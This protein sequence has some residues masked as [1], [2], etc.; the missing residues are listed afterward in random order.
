M[1][2]HTVIPT[3]LLLIGVATACAS[4]TDGAPTASASAYLT[5]TR[6]PSLPAPLLSRSPAPTPPASTAPAPAAPVPDPSADQDARY[7]AAVRAH[8]P[9]LARVSDDNPGVPGRLV[10]TLLDSGDSPE[11]VYETM[12]YSYPDTAKA[13][14]T[15]APPVYCPQYT[16]S[17]NTAVR[18]TPQVRRR[19][20]HRPPRPPC[21]SAGQGRC[22]PRAMVCG[23]HHP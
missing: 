6:L 10:C 2:R 19:G 1:R 23:T 22:A 11:S 8:A 20:P 21:P 4:S 18:Q 17:V 3:T 14:T 5:A 12:Q 16:Q 9:S 13:L 7:A 15:Q